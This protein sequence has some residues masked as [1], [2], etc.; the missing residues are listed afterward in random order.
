VKELQRHAAEAAAGRSDRKPSWQRPEVS[1]PPP[2]IDAM[3]HPILAAH[4]VPIVVEGS[5]GVSAADAALLGAGIAAVA[6][7]L[8]AIVTSFLN[9]VWQREREADHDDVIFRQARSARITKQLSGLYGPLRMLTSQSAALTDKLREGKPDPGNWHLLHHLKVVVKDPADK[10][11]TEQIIAINGEIEQRIL[12]KAGLLQDGTVPESFLAFLGH[13]R[14]LKIA[15]EAAVNAEDVPREITAKKF[16]SYP[17]DF[18]DDVKAGYE[19]LWAERK[20]LGA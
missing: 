6:S 9:H 2:I 12:D 16:E 19:S 14:M 4:Q 17:R 20:G 5:H 8:T 11:I 1:S 13:Y 10:A 3:V 18:D 7:L 15:F